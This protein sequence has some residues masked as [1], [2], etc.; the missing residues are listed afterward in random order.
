M[1]KPKLWYVITDGGLK[2]ARGFFTRDKSGVIIGVDLAG[3][4][5]NRIPT[6]SK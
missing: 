4:V 6:T 2:G 3:R 1:K 5:F